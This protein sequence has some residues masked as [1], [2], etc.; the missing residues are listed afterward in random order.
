ML[1]NGGGVEITV[2]GTSFIITN[3]TSNYMVVRVYTLLG[4]T[5]TII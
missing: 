3:K 4:N 2:S 5:P 1:D